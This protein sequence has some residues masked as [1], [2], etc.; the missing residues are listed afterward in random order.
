MQEAVGAGGLNSCEIIPFGILA[1]CIDWSSAPP[2]DRDICQTCV[3]RELEFC[4]TVEI[5]RKELSQ[6]HA[7]RRDRARPR[8]RQTASLALFVT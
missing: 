2:I 7:A 3:D 6:C 8:L 5:S 1:A 4:E